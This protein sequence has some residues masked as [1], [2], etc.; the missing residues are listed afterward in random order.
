MRLGR[1]CPLPCLRGKDLIRKDSIRNSEGAGSLAVDEFRKK[2][3]L[4]RTRKYTKTYYV[5]R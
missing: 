4:T 1:L 5:S 2:W 3:A